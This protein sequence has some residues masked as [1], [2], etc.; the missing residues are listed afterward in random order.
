MFVRYGFYH[1]HVDAE[2]CSAFDEYFDREMVP[3][4]AAFPGLVSVRLLRGRAP[5]GL[6]PRFHHAIEL[7]FPDETAMLEAMRSPQ[8]RAAMAAQA[9]IMHLYHG[10]TPHANFELVSEI[11]GRIDQRARTIEESRR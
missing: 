11:P 3:L 1:G 8:R 4:L 6:P 9:R 10:A 2:D 5:A 7:S